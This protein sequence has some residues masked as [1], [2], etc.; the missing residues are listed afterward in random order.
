M[1]PI[2]IEEI[3]A[4]V[5]AYNHASNSELILEAY[6]LAAEYHKDQRRDSGEP[7]IHHPLE[8]AH[9]LAS[10][11]IDDTTIIAGL[12]HDMMEDTKVDPKL[13]EEK[14]G[15]AALVLVQ[16]VTK[17]SRLEFR[18]RHDAQAESLRKMFMAMSSD[19]RIILVKLADRLHNMR[20]IDSHHSMLRQK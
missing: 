20:T 5:K 11:Q 19:I 4:E 15:H 18:T 6:H 17:L 1:P 12:L 16:G 7:Y 3:I 10:M 8:V 13:I 14:F 9:I 2:T